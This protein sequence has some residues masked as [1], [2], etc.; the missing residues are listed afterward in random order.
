M[1]YPGTRRVSEAVPV[2]TLAL[3]VFLHYVSRL[4]CRAGRL[5]S[6]ICLAREANDEHQPTAYGCRRALPAF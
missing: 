5:S 3:S 4:R 2:S 1:N 6:Y